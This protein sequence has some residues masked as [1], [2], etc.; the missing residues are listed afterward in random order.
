MN[1]QFCMNDMTMGVLNAARIAWK[2]NIQGQWCGWHYI[3]ALLDR[4][5]ISIPEHSHEFQKKF[6]FLGKSMKGMIF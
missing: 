5:S 2:K 1:L 4:V 6:I 3:V